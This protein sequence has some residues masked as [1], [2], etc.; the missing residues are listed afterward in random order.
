M[1][2]ALLALTVAWLLA[3]YGYQPWGVLDGRLGDVLVRYDAGQRAPP[4]DIVLINI[5]QASLDD[6]DMLDV[7]GNWPWPRAINGALLVYL[8]CSPPRA[9]CFDRIF[10]DPVQFR[11]QRYHVR[12]HGRRTY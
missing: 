4:D 3:L 5:D 10:I 1:L 11:H 9:V 6:P 2:A 8:A 7:A 12:E